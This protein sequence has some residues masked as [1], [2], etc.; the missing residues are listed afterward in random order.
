MSCSVDTETIAVVALSHSRS[1]THS[2]SWESVTYSSLLILHCLTK[3][4]HMDKHRWPMKQLWLQFSS[5]KK[6]A[7]KMKEGG[8][9]PKQWW[10]KS[11]QNQKRYKNKRKNNTLVY[12]LNNNN[13]NK[14]MEPWKHLHISFLLCRVQ[15]LH[16]LKSQWLPVIWWHSSLIY[17]LP[18]SFWS[19]CTG[20]ALSPLN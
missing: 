15:T 7:N 6:K 19:Y 13:N 4:K 18:S 3:L 16:S 11:L 12:Y 20:Q 9:N 2:L 14:K 8:K 17:I 5:K 10:S 1:L